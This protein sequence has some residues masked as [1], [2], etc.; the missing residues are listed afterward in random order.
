[1]VNSTLAAGDTPEH[2]IE[3]EKTEG[4]SLLSRSMQRSP[5][6]SV[7]AVCDRER[8]VVQ[9]ISVQTDGHAVFAIENF[10][11]IKLVS[12]VEGDPVEV[13]FAKVVS[14]F[15]GDP[16]CF[17]V[18]GQNIADTPEILAELSGKPILH[19]FDQ[20]DIDL[21]GQGGGAF[22]FLA[23]ALASMNSN[24]PKT[25]A[26]LLVGESLRLVICDSS[27]KSILKGGLIAFDIGAGWR[28]GV[29]QGP[30]AEIFKVREP[31]RRYIIENVRNQAQKGWE[32]ILRNELETAFEFAGLRPQNVFVAGPDDLVCRVLSLIDLATT[33][34]LGLVPASYSAAAIAFARHEISFHFRPVVLTTQA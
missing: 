2:S 16:A 33:E 1:M 24:L 27:D 7:G 9:G 10:V 32:D 11:E 21:G 29:W 26:I 28:E 30:T 20:S 15:G 25:F 6:V 8:K 3:A 18:V 17:G 23:F 14:S 12:D 22:D 4:K 5:F 31:P 19:D 13:A 34:R